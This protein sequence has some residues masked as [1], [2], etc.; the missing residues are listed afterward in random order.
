MLDDNISLLSH[1]DATIE[2]NHKYLPIN[3][4]STSS[5]S[6]MKPISNA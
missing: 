2:Q 4:S 6:M 5:H 3:T 1:S